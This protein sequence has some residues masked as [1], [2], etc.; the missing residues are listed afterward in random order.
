MSQTLKIIVVVVLAMLL[1]PLAVYAN[2]GN[3][4]GEFDFRIGGVARVVPDQV[5]DTVIVIDGDAVVDGQVSST[6]WVINGTVTVS[7][8]VDGE[9]MVVDGVL[10]LASTARVGNVQLVR[11]VLERGDGA[12]IS[13][14][15]STRTE[16]VHFGWGSGVFSTIFWIVSTIALVIAAV[17]ILAIA[18]RR[19][20][21]ATLELHS[22]LLSSAG[23][24]F[25]LWTALTLL[26]L[27]AAI[28]LV[29]IPLSLGIALFVMPVIWLV[30]YVIAS[31]RLGS[32]VTRLVRSGSEATHH[33]LFAIVGLIAF[34]CIGLIPYVGGAVVGLAGFIGSGALAYRLYVDWRA[35]RSGT[36]MSPLL[37]PAT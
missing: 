33:Y 19:L 25:I 27:M 32:V 28:T 4:Q 7:G 29:G 15:V 12:T 18:G 13:G 31:M 1:M 21:G 6:L 10:N 34:Q 26:A 5:V 22:H 23:A 3:E 20:N 17:F 30:G 14:E 36:G 8:V 35:R 11:S 9:I 16:F 2:D 24:A 37:A